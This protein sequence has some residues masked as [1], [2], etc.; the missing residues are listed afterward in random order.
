MN[1]ILKKMRKQLVKMLKKLVSIQSESYNTKAM[2]RY[3]NQVVQSIPGCTTS[4]D[5]YG[6]IYV[7]KGQAETYPCMVCHIDTVHQ[8]QRDEVVPIQIDQQL[9]AVFRNSLKQTGTGGDDKCGIVITLQN[10]MHLDKFKAVFFLDEEVGCVGSSNANYKFFDNVRY[11][12]ECDR[13]GHQDFV[14]NISGCT[15]FDKKFEDAIAPY[16]SKY[17]RKI[18]TGGLTD[19]YEI[20]LETDLCV[21]NMS[22]G[23][24]NP[25]TDCEYIDLDDVYDTFLLT[26]DLFRYVTDVY[27]VDTKRTKYYNYGYNYAK[28]GY[29]PYDPYDVEY[30]NDEEEV[31][32]TT[33]CGLGCAM[34]NGYCDSCHMSAE[35]LQSYFYHEDDSIRN[36]ETGPRLLE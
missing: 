31:T 7:T 33:N 20:A 5:K 35:E 13:K 10:L 23:Y 30:E 32:D 1:V 8:I 4:F 18:T 22:C 12:L 14:N 29:D 21:A 6:N 11:V 9:I 28:F 17:G 16:L 24:Y 27:K 25:H 2:A 36:Q 26:H 19:V 34:R 15:L 3:I